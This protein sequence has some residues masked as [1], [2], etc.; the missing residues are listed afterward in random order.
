MIK[1]D[2]PEAFMR[3]CTFITILAL[4]CLGILASPAFAD[5]RVALVIGNSAYR[6]TPFLPNPRNDAQDVAAALKLSGFETIVGVDLDKA[7]MDEAT[8]KFARAARK[9]DVAMFYYSG[10]ALQ[11]AGINYLIP[12]DAKLADDA[13]LR[14]MTK[15]DDIVA[16]LESAKSLRILVL[17]ACRDNPLVEQMQRAVGR[18]RALSLQRGLAKIDSPEGMIIAYSTQAGSTADDGAGRNSPYT[19]AFLRHIEEQEE[20]ATI[21]RR[22]AADVYETT[23]HGQI[24][25]LS[26]SLIGEFYLRGRLDINV[27]SQPP[28]SDPCVAASD[29]WKSAEAIGTV[30]AFEDHVA[31]FPNC[32][33]AGLA[34]SKIAALTAVSA[35]MPGAD[36]RRFDGI[37][38]AK[39]ACESQAPVWPAESYQ[40]TANVRDGVF[41]A[42]TGVEGMPRFRSYDGKIQPDGTAEIFVKGLTGDTELDPIHRPAG[43]EYRWKVAGKFEGSH[44][45][46]VRADER[47]CHFDFAMLTLPAA[48]SDAQR[49]DG[50]WMT[51]VGCDAVPPNVQ[52]WST[53]FIGR[54]K[55]AEFRGQTGVEGKPGWTVYSGKIEPDGNVEIDANGQIGNPEFG[56]HPR[57]TP[58]IW[59]AA[60]R[61]EGAH[62]NAV[63][64]EGR[65]CNMDF[66]KQVVAGPAGADRGGG[67]EFKPQEVAVVPPA[68]PSAPRP[69]PSLDVQRKHVVQN[70]DT[71]SCKARY[72]NALSRVPAAGGLACKQEV[73]VLDGTCGAG[74]IRKI[75]GGCNLGR[76]GQPN[77]GNPRITSC[78]TC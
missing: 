25:E 67:E 10:H 54:V 26:L 31:R 61:F 3:R 13:D 29:H 9:A 7:S 39:V 48:R 52:G 35:P 33:F 74:K 19:E 37:W 64:V 12:I 56:G 70:W 65:R 45:V 58:Y 11:F 5:K 63:R 17:D 42:Q 24:P 43:T 68:Q 1:Y 15:V 46:G 14:L 4:L 27:H 6:N 62:G 18:R 72:P 36:L 49:F 51:T 21:F 38:V 76:D 32:P 40:F 22:V 28:V 53:K 20:I 2:F 77:A 66:A 8:I 47:T 60:G 78:V 16:D 23:G 73:M 57:G 30:A 69:L 71:A 75:V 55:N 50:L 34:K 59:R 44:G 41:H